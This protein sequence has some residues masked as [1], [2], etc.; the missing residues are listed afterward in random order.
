M[1]TDTIRSTADILRDAPYYQLLF[2]AVAVAA[3]AAAVGFVRPFRHQRK[4]SAGLLLVAAVM[5]VWG[6]R[7]ALHQERVNEYFFNTVQLANANRGRSEL[8]NAQWVHICESMHPGFVAD[9]EAFTGAPWSDIPAR[10]QWRAQRI[11][12]LTDRCARLAA[13]RDA[14]SAIVWSPRAATGVGGRIDR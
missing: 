11:K 3:L 12:E 13:K 9:V 7:L 6:G 4:A 1:N 5:A 10:E 2:G 8:E 14:L